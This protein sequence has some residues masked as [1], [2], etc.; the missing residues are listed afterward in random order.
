MPLDVVK[1]SEQED[2]DLIRLAVRR[3]V[4]AAHVLLAAVKELGR[5]W[6]EEY[7]ARRAVQAA[8]A[9]GENILIKLRENR[10]DR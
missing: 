10:R 8:D 1:S 6:S 9:L 5:P 7:L 3:H 2:I 4:E